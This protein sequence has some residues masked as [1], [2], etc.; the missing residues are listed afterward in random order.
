MIRALL[1][2]AALGPSLAAQAWRPVPVGTHAELRGLAVPRPGIVWIA[3]SGGTVKVTED[4]G[5]TWRACAVPGGDALDFRAVAALDARRAWILSVG[6]GDLGRI[7][8]TED[9][10]RSW[11]LQYRNAPGQG[12][13][14]ALA[15]RDA[16]SGFALGDPIRGRFQLLR[17]EDGGASWTPAPDPA[18]P[19]ARPGEG[20]FAA[21]NTCFR[22]GSEG[23]IWFVTGSADRTRAFHSRDDGRTWTATETPVPAGSASRGLFTLVPLGPDRA[24]ALGGDHQQP[25][26]DALNGAATD[27]GGR[28][29]RPAPAQPAGYR[30]GAATVPG[31]PGAVI[32]VGPTGTGLSLDEGRTWRTLDALPLNAVACADA[33]TLWAVGPKGAVMQWD[34]AFPPAR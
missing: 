20:A 32:A 7:Y 30:S 13:L 11:T 5:A 31:V 27:D 25:G 22:L 4:G 1:L 33:R 14:D 8:R 29:W 23:E 3:G 16:R 15:F 26:L 21:S 19:A 17:T 10:G 18:F 9:G 6:T 34:G 2:L 28:T 24:L 12:F